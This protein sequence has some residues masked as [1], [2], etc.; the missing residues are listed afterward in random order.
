[1]GR[2]P[3]VM[4]S[5]S[6]RRVKSGSGV[7]VFHASAM[8]IL[9]PFFGVWTSGNQTPRFAP[10]DGQDPKN[11]DRLQGRLGLWVLRRLASCASKTQA[12]GCASTNSTQ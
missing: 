3:S 5:P 6:H 11:A 1:M 10:A 8:F 2:P 12:G 9:G 7:R 4:S